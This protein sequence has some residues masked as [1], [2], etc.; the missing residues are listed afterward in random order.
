MV[1]IQSQN[2]PVAWRQVRPITTNSGPNES[3][4]PTL[5]VPAAAAPRAT[6]TSFFREQSRYRYSQVFHSCCAP[7]P[8]LA[9]YMVTPWYTGRPPEPPTAGGFIIKHGTGNRFQVSQGRGHFSR[10][11]RVSNVGLAIAVNAWEWTS[12]PISDHSNSPS[13][14]L[15]PLPSS[16]HPKQYARGRSALLFGNH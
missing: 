16:S 9:V 5:P 3:G 1:T 2:A 7:K 6:I 8:R 12:K 10:Y 13:L 4:S 11:P 14:I 15:T